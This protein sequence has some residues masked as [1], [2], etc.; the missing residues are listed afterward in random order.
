MLIGSQPD[1]VVAGQ[2]GSAAQALTL[3][4][5]EVVDV[6]LIDIRLPLV[7]GFTVAGRIR[8]DA[9]VRAHGRAPRIILFATLDLD[10]QVPAAASAGA[11]AVLY[12]GVEPEALLAAVREAAAAEGE[13]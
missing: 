10:D 13:S 4:R 9:R 1:L 6:V 12:K 5:R 8:D 2:A 11:Y 3:V 7:D